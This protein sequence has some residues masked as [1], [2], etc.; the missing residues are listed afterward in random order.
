M[1]AV[2]VARSERSGRTDEYLDVMTEL[3]TQQAPAY[4][5]RYVDFDHVDA[6]PRPVLSGGPRIV[7]GGHSPA[8]FRRAVAR[9]HGWFGH[10]RTPDDLVN[11]L[12]GL[13]KA[14]TE[15]ERPA[16]L[17]RLEITFMQ[18]DPVEVDADT[19]RRYADL[20][21]DRLLIYPL[22]L[23]DPDKVAAFGRA[24]RQPLSTL[25]SI[26]PNISPLLHSLFI[27]SSSVD[28]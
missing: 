11:H 7:V 25:T 2:G 1:T 22:P 4:H 12:A 13:R 14:A 20:G 27:N 9:G 3:W 16:H 28:T 26:E 19:A 5:G 10:G 6:H 8:A 17:G 15:V 21:V 23:E 24:A 18:V